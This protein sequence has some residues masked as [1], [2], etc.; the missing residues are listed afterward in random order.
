V[1]AAIPEPLPHRSETAI[2]RFRK[3]G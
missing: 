3:G 2:G 1:A